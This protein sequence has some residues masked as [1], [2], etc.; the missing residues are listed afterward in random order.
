M[1]RA[2]KDADLAVY[3]HKGRVR[4]RAGVAAPTWEGTA[5][6]RQQARTEL[7]QQVRPMAPNLTHQSRLRGREQDPGVVEKQRRFQKKFWEKTVR[8]SSRRT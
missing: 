6:L 5:K 4:F 8:G 3:A 7:Q 1:K 2:I